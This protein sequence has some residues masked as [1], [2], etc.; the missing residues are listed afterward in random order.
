[1]LQV[2]GKPFVIKGMNYAPVPIG[3]LPGQDPFGD[4]FI[5]EYANVWKPDIDNIRKAGVNV[6]KL[7]AG[8][9]QR[10]AGETGT[11]GAWKQFLDYCWNGGKDPIY[12]VMFSFT[13]G[14]V[15]K[16][17]GTG[18]DG[19]MDDYKKLVLS[20]VEHPAVFG[21]IIGNEIFD[22]VTGSAQFWINFGKLIDAAETAGLSVGKKPFLT[23]ATKDD[24]AMQNGSPTI[25]LG[26]K[27]GRLKNLDAW[28]VNVY[29]GPE[30]GGSGDSPFTQYADLMKQ[31]GLIK[32]L[33]LGEWG[34]PHT[35]REV[36]YYGQNTIDHLI[37]LDTVPPNL[38]GPG[39]P[40]FD[41][42]EVGPYLT[43]LWNVITGNVGAKNAQVC[44]GGFIFEWSDEYWKAGNQFRSKQVGGPD[45][46]FMK[47]KYAGSYEDEAGFGVTSDVDASAY[48]LGRPDIWR[49]PFKGYQA[50]TTFYNASSHSG[51]E[52]Y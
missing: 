42:K 26:E 36:P 29:R 4:Y 17:G 38:I 18:L 14:D 16:N 35:T 7:Y 2:D 11:A 9:P 10:N 39:M 52:L 24:L 23:T 32:P 45:P 47:S 5:P 40:Y 41:A 48:G 3:V 31:L 27:S 34:T 46:N 8:N 1:M 19:Y 13:V 37:D 21:Y 20:T 49:K 22:G 12:V 51:G 44:V 50:V 25:K 28:S 43:G 33:I 6:I 15:I 30:L